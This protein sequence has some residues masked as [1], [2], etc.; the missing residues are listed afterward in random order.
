MNFSQKLVCFVLF[1]SKIATIFVTAEFPQDDDSGISWITIDSSNAP[2]WNSFLNMVQQDFVS[3]SSLGY[4]FNESMTYDVN[5]ETIAVQG[6]SLYMKIN[7]GVTLTIN[8]PTGQSFL[9]ILQNQGYLGIQGDLVLQGN[10]ISQYPSGPNQVFN[11]AGGTLSL[12]GVTIQNFVNTV[13][14]IAADAAPALIGSSSTAIFTDVTFKNNVGYDVSCI[15]ISIEN[16]VTFNSVQV[17]SCSVSQSSG[18]QI[19]V[20]GGTDTTVSGSVNYEN[21]SGNNIY[22]LYSGSCSKLGATGTD[23]GMS[24]GKIA[25][26]VVPIVIIVL[27]GMGGAAYYINYQSELKRKKQRQLLNQSINTDVKP[28]TSYSQF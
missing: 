23:T 18:A 15:F 20:V 24:S 14:G 7:S 9:F 8:V 27:C 10:V 28:S 2:T 5:T 19:Y 6:K 3:S 13:G 17:D 11:V 22:C 12:D 26:I 1:L 4:E 16:E 25:A 21:N